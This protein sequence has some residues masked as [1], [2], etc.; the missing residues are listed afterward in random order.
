ME[1]SRGFSNTVSL[2]DTAVFVDVCELARL[3]FGSP[4]P[5][6]LEIYTNLLKMR[7]KVWT[8][9]SPQVQESPDPLRGVKASERFYGFLISIVRNEPRDCSS[10]WFLFREVFVLTVWR[11]ALQGS[12][13]TIMN[14]HLRGRSLQ[15]VVVFPLTSS[16]DLLKVSTCEWVWRHRPVCVS[17]GLVLRWLRLRH[18]SCCACWSGGAEAGEARG[19]RPAPVFHTWR[20]SN[21]DGD[22]QTP[23]TPNN[24]NPPNTSLLLSSWVVVGMKMGRVFISLNWSSV[25]SRP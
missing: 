6:W 24:V 9:E 10:C 25:S 17:A 21:K 11:W 15:E 5:G 2:S 18:S 14:I 8:K 22:V 23:L 4:C 16:L 20:V 12:R 1:R 13:R 3:A 7:C 19:L